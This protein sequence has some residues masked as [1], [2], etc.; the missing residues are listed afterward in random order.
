MTNVV[1]MLLDSTNQWNA[2]IR[3]VSSTHGAIFFE[4]HVNSRPAK[5][6][7]TDITLTAKNIS[8][9]AGTNFTSELSLRWNGEGSVKTVT[10]ASLAPATG[11][12]REE[13]Q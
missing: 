3:N 9:L 6:A 13:F 4:D 8:N 7:L 11:S 5:A 12:L 10:T 2:T 1:A